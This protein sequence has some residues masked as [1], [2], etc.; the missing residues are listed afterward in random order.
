MPERRLGGRPFSEWGTISGGVL[1]G[2]SVVYTR[3]DQVGCQPLSTAP[4]YVSYTSVNQSRFSVSA[5]CSTSSRV[6]PCFS[7]QP[8]RQQRLN[9]LPL[10]QGQESL[11]PT[12]ADCAELCTV[13]GAGGSGAGARRGGSQDC[14]AAMGPGMRSKIESSSGWGGGAMAMARMDWAAFRRT[15]AGVEA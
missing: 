2:T 4:H 13:F 5:Q 9:F 1:S 8:S 7:T 6:R 15:M 14:G 3:Y 11:R 12:L 10:P